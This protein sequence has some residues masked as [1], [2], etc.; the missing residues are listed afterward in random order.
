MITDNK[1]VD[2]AHAIKNTHKFDDGAPNQ[3]KA[4]LDFAEQYH[5]DQMSVN[6]DFDFFNDA[7]IFLNSI[8]DCDKVEES[9]KQYMLDK[10]FNF[11]EKHLF[12]HMLQTHFNLI[13]TI[14][15]LKS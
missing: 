12:C 2:L 8:I 11:N 15:K 9:I 14:A 6:D 4:M 13:T 1:Y 10:N 7:R 5:K 3:I